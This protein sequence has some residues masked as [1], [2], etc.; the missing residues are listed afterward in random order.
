MGKANAAAEK[1][2]KITEYP[3]KIDAMNECRDPSKKTLEV[4][5]I[6]GKI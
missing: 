3:S 2:F 1:I 4:E 5:N 6:E